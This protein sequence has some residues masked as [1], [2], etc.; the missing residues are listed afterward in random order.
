MQ[1]QVVLRLPRAAVSVSLARHVVST[2]LKRAGV[3][4]DCLADVELAVSE[5]CTNAYLHS[6]A[7]GGYEV[8]VAIGDE[9][10][11]IDV[12]D[13]GGGFGDAA[14]TGT[15]SDVSAESGRG[16]ALMAAYSDSAAFESVI[17]GGGTVHLS[18]RLCWLE[19]APL[20]GSEV[21]AC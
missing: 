19:D 11:T 6:S 17:D 13:S 10:M 16:L 12:I 7:Q 2:A 4:L 1:F 3:T 14:T 18:K 9:L 5:A 8:V 21:T 20:R 15:M